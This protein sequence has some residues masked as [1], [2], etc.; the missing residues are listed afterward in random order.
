MFFQ[1]A[2]HVV[3]LCFVKIRMG[4]CNFACMDLVLSYTD[5]SPAIPQSME[6]GLAAGIIEKEEIDMI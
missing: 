4:L 3:Q 6:C 1:V 5:L 2:N